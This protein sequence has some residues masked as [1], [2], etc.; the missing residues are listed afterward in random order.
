MELSITSVTHKSTEGKHTFKAIKLSLKM[1]RLAQ[2]WTPLQPDCLEK[3]G[4]DD[5]DDYK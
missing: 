3:W 5:D 4:D 2:N 1:P